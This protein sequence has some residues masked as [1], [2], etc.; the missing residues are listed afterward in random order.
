MPADHGPAR[1]SRA[2]SASRSFP[3][4]AWVDRWDRIVLPAAQKDRLL[5]H[6][7]FSL[8]HRGRVSAGRAAGPWPASCSRARRAPAR[9]RSPGGLADQAA[10]LLDG[11]PLLFVDI[12][13]HSFPSQLLGESQRDRR[14]AVRAHPARPR[15]A[16]PAHGRAARRGRGARREPQRRLAGDQPGGRPPGHGCRA[17][18]RG[19][20]GLALPQRDVRG[21]HQPPPRAWTPRSCPARTWSRRSG[22]PG[23]DAIA[24]HPRGHPGRAGRPRRWPT[25]P[26]CARWRTH[27]PRRTWTRARCAS[28]CCA[29]S[30]PRGSS[31]S[32]RPG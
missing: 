26:V 29:R 11:P 7:L 28:S 13:P 5:N 16:R 10:R 2:S 9:R 24:R 12:D 30:A 31:R 18:G 4:P 17:R 20:G 22:Y 25:R 1:A 6:L 23:A 8:R 19:P 14:A 21:H 27:A 3:D 15:E 32:I